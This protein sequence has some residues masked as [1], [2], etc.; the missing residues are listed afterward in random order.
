MSNS[1]MMTVR[2]LRPGVA[3]TKGDIY[4]GAA[5]AFEE[6]R[7]EADQGLKRHRTSLASGEEDV[8]KMSAPFRSQSSE[9]IYNLSSALCFQPLDVECKNALR[10]KEANIV[11]RLPS[12]VSPV[13]EGTGC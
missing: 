8:G 11:P 1:N 2:K 7:R 12:Q 10:I 13:F 6:V 3:K 9:Y 5:C 4:R